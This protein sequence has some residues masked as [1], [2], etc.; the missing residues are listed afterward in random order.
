[1]RL[2]RFFLR[3]IIYLVDFLFQPKFKQRSFDEQQAMDNKTSHLTLYEMRACPFCVR[4]RW[5]LK[6]MGINIA[7]K[8]TKRDVYARQRLIVNGG[9]VQV[10][11]LHIAKED[12]DVW[13]YESKDIIKYLEGE[14]GELKKA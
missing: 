8:D 14:F 2:I 11:C 6:R 5:A 10:P 4:V 7:T 9:K 13:M 3:Y 1:M 12:G